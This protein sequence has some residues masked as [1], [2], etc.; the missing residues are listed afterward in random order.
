VAL[1]LQ[2]ID[3]N[4]AS[5]QKIMLAATIVVTILAIIL[6]ALI[7]ARISR[8]IRDLT[9]TAWQ[10]ANEDP[11]PAGGGD[12]IGQLTRVYMSA[13]LS[14]EI[15]E[16]EAER[17]TLLEVLQ[18]MTDGVFIIDAQGDIQLVNPA[19]EKMFSISHQG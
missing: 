1:P 18:K 9:S 12:E 14:E 8:P 10:L 3:A 17:A 5:L 2:Q 16:L 15:N 11:D 7:A 19:A 6:A 4:I 13:R